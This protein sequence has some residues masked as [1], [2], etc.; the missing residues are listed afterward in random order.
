VAERSRS[1]RNV[2]HRDL[3]QARRDVGER[4]EEHNTT[5]L[6]RPARSA[7]RESRPV[8]A[9]RPVRGE[10][11]R[12]RGG[13]PWWIWL[14]GLAVLG[15]IAFMISQ[16]LAG[17]SSTETDARATAEA[18]SGD[19][20]ADGS[21]IAAGTVSSSDGVD[22]LSLSTDSSALASYEEKDV[23]GITA[24]VESVVGDEAFWV[25]PSREQRLFVFLN[26]QGE[27]GPEVNAGDEVTFEGTMKALPIDFVER[28][29]V[30]S[31]EGA[32]HL[33]QQGRYIEARQIEKR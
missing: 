3:R 32:G 17:D 9:E 6:E 14:L 21:E 28:F 8:R 4:A 26:L 18:T 25:G 12:S 33:E 19:S 11:D 24:P 5:R 7:G 31:P 29:D 1:M 23:E 10:R 27:S 22:L 15:L 2:R 30:S 20:S 13:T 16:G